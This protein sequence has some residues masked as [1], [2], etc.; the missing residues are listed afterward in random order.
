[1]ASKVGANAP[2]VGVL[3]PRSFSGRAVT[4]G[5]EGFAYKPL[6]GF[7]F[8]SGF[9]AGDGGDF[10]AVSHLEEKCSLVFGGC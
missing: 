2:P 7:L 8:V 4:Q 6:S 10:P 1:M 3:S 5:L 9:D